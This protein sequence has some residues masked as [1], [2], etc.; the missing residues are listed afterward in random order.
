MSETPAPTIKER[1]AELTANIEKGIQDL[2]QSDGYAKYLR[3]MAQFHR[4]SLG[5]TML[6]YLQKPEATL[7]AGFDKWKDR[8]SRNVKK[9]EKGIRIIAPVPYRKTVEQEKLDPVTGVP[10]LD[11]DGM[12]ITE[13]KVIRVPRFKP[14]TV[15]D[16]SQTYGKPLPELVSDLTG[17]VQGYEVLMEALRRSSPVPIT[18]KTMASN[19]DGSYN[20]KE[21]S[22]AIW[23]G[24][25]EPQTISAVIHEMA[26][27]KLHS[28]TPAENDKPAKDRG[29]AEV[30]AESVS[31]AVCGYYG[32]ATGEN[33]FGYVASWSKGKELNELK[34]ALETINQTA[35][36]LI[37]DIDRH[38][39][40]IRRERGLD[41]E[42][43]S[44]AAEPVQEIAV[45]ETEP[46]KAPGNGD[47][48]DP[49]IS[50]ESMNAYGY[51]DPNM[52][53]LTKER[54][55]ELM[56]RDVTVYML[57][58]D[59][60]ESMAFGAEEVRSFDGM[61]GI[62][63]SEWE[64]VKDRF[65]P[66]PDYEAVFL[67]NPA[68][69][70]AI[71]QFRDGENTAALRFMNSEYLEQKGFSIEHDNYAAVYAGDLKDTG[72]T[73]DRLNTLYQTFNVDHPD[74]FRGH[75][76]SVSDI[77]ALRQ[78]GVV[79]CHYVDSQGFKE[80]SGFIKPENYLKN[81]EMALEDDYGM[82]D[83]IVNNGPKQTIPEREAE[84]AI[85]CQEKKPSVL[86]KLH[87]A[88]CEPEKSVRTANAER[89][90]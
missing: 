34:S 65:A 68:D 41:K 83:G 86:A 2:F 59:N 50:V 13:E 28:R 39:A 11:A 7:V 8:F 48:P 51:T 21:K 19:M 25:S 56:E 72:D 60:T 14:V 36:A 81:A 33:S 22:I 38:V 84:K 46:V 67:N 82:I 85:L 73:Q 37:A 17:S 69:S 27:A 53:P 30:E 5:N 74:G 62:E 42:T 43:E 18:L 57:H 9:G 54:A 63:A 71:Y 70:Y 61:F 32:I 40:D 88:I 24:M 55:L 47:V 44:L 16:V 4:Y 26:H 3:T 29:T 64:T 90:L 20:D 31:Y 58:T 12:A 35:S 23:E 45:Q 49:A 6:I 15:F 77:V 75:S 89:G 10:L 1:L 76:L 87:P 52:L 79:S 66:M 78:N 80:I